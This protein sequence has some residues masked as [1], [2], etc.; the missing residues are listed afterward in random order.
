MERADAAKWVDLRPLHGQEHH[1]A[2]GVWE[3]HLPG[4]VAHWGGGLLPRFVAVRRGPPYGRYPAGL[5]PG[6]GRQNIR[7]R[8][9]KVQ[10]WLNILVQDAS[11]P[12]CARQGPTVEAVE[13]FLLADPGMGGR[14]GPPL[15]SGGDGRAT[16]AV[17]PVQIRFTAVLCAGGRYI[18]VP[19][20]VAACRFLDPRGGF[21]H[22]T[23]GDSVPP[24]SREPERRRLEGCGPLRIRCR[25][26][27]C[28][29]AGI[30]GQSCLVAAEPGVP[31][32][33]S[34][35]IG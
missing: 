10:T 16:T 15:G 35:G 18:A 13:V 6:G 14:V 5:L 11:L 31:A 20:S 26:G 2:Y 27:A 29:Y 9:R 17:P 1:V 24:Q 22:L 8:P 28:Q 7:R 23:P 12:G 32:W 30:G 19:V 3:L 25:N 4:A 33:R 34:R 21:R